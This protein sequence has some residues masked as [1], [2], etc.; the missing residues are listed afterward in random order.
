MN[1][2]QAGTP[3]TD[4]VKP[5]NCSDC[6]AATQLYGIEG[7]RPGYELLTFVCRKCE[8]IETAAAKVA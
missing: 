6:G 2:Y 1:L 8:H 3:H 7:E 4:F 5:P